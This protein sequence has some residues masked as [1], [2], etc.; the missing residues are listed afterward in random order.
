[1][2]DMKLLAQLQLSNYDSCGTW[3]CECDSGFQM[4]FGRIREMLKLNPELRID[5]IGPRRSTLRTQPE[6]ILPDLFASNRVNWIEIDIIANALA[7]RYEF[8][9]SQVGDALKLSDPQH[10][11]YDAVY[12][13]DPMLLRHYKALFLL[14]GKYL[15]RYYVHSHFID[16]EEVPKFPKEASL[17]LGQCEAAIKADFN[18]WQCESAMNVFFESMAKQFQP[19]IVD[20]VRAKSLPWDDGFSASEINVPVDMFNVRFTQEEWKAKTQGKIVLFFPNRISPSSGDYTNGM[21]FMFELLPKLRS[22]RQDFVVVCGNPNQKFSNAE[23]EEKCGK[24]GYVSLTPDVFNRDEYKFVAARSDIALG[25][26]NAD[27]YG[28]TAARECV[29]LG[30]MPQWLDNFEYSSLAREAGVEEYVLA[31]PDFSDFVD[32]LDRIM[33]MTRPQRQDIN[34]RLKSVVRQRC[35]YEETTHKAMQKMDLLKV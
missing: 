1:M 18:F 33:S 21:K 2:S 8:N 15:P 4:V 22:R 23:L 19:S 25:L 20:A 13:N 11:R 10:E 31:R 17:W 5:V 27:A 3:I 29:E 35:S 24:D 6:D 9:F 32:V 16:N 7:T 28:G 30:C 34:Q 12:I 26:Y 14:V